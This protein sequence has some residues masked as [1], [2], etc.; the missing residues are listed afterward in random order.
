M[1]IMRVPRIMY[2]AAIIYYTHKKLRIKYNCINNN[3]IMDKKGSK[4]S[5]G[6][7]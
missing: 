6:A 5:R 2:Y 7:S 1:G 4:N 3:T